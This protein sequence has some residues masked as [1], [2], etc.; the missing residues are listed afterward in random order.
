MIPCTIDGA[1]W[2]SGN[3]CYAYQVDRDPDDPAWKGHKDGTLWQCLRDYL[4]GL[5]PDSPIWWVG[6]GKEPAP[7]VADPAVL[8]QEA[9]ELLRLETAGVNT[10]PTPPDMTYVNLETW[11]WI[12]KAQWQP[13]SKSVSAGATTVT[14][15][16]GP[17]HVLWDTGD[18]SSMTC[19]SPGVAWEDWMTSSATTDCQYVYT[20]LPPPDSA[21]PV[22]ATIVYS[23]DWTCTGVCIRDT[24]TL[25]EVDG[26]TGT[27]NLRVGERQ[28]VVVE[29]D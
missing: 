24:G 16:A 9:L 14:V 23:V 1:V 15:T 2:S 29:I 18:G 21:F 6:P 12:A 10:A 27:Q 17:D 8:A 25:G 22:S 11:L 13:L 26:V 7:P 4:G 28:S 20:T 19:E 3:A 5:T